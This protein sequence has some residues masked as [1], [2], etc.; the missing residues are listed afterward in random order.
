[1]SFEI[2]VFFVIL[3]SFLWNQKGEGV[4]WKHAR[5]AV[6]LRLGITSV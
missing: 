3:D 6:A 4:Y 1:M 5:A 2:P